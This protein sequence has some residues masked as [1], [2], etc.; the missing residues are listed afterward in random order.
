MS[1]QRCQFFADLFNDDYL[2]HLAQSDVWDRIVSIEYQGYKQVYDLTVPKYHNFVAQ[3]F[4]VHNTTFA[5]NLVENAMMVEEK[6]SIPLFGLEMPSE[7][8]MMRMLAS[9]SRVDQTK[10]RTAQLDEGLGPIVKYHGAAK[11][12]D[13]VH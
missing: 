13:C 11:D 1:R 12:K 9:L 6:A 5:M 4:F 8:L 7:Q 2:K 3:D 10:I